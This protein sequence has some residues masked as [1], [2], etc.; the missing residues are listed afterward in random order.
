LPPE[1]PPTISISASPG[2]LLSPWQTVTFT[3]TPG[4]NPGTSP[5]YQWK[6]NGTN[7]IGATANNWSANNLSDNDDISCII[8]SSIICAD[9]KSVE[10]NKIKINIKTGINDVAFNKLHIYPNPVQEELIVEGI[11]KGTVIEIS[12][13]VGRKLYSTIA[14]G[15]SIH[16]NTSFLSKGNYLLQ[17]HN[18]D[19]R[20]VV[21]IVKE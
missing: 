13:I 11:L 3:A 18:A 14:D 16:I 15:N 20:K 19:G 7:V 21:K 5:T 17:L 2:T 4:G 9:P 8:T 1:A 10:S 12:D 6:R